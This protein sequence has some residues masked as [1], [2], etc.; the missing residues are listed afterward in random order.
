MLGA[1]PVAEQLS[2]SK[3]KILQGAYILVVEAD[4]GGGEHSISG[5]EKVFGQKLSREG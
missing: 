3:T 4:A 5:D 2:T 1:S